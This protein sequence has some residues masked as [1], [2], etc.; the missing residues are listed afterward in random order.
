MGQPC[1]DGCQVPELNGSNTPMRAHSQCAESGAVKKEL[2]SSQKSIVSR[3]LCCILNARIPTEEEG[4]YCPFLV[5]LEQS[6]R[7][8]LRELLADAVVRLDAFAG[9]QPPCKQTVGLDLEGVNKVD[10]AKH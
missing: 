9:K 2:W 6:R 3:T 1:L 7:G 8:A 10:K 4:E 5:L